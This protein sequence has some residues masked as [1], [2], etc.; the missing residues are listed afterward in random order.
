MARSSHDRPDGTEALCSMQRFGRCRLCELLDRDGPDYSETYRRRYFPDE[1]PPAESWQP[2]EP[3]GLLAKAGNLA[4]AT[5]EHLIAGLPVADE[6]T[7]AM[8]ME[9]CRACVGPT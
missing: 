9:T 5:A 8:R 6:A 7:Q 2:P 1:F 4:K 3:I